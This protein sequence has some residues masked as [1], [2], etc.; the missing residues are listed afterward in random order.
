MFKFLAHDDP[1]W[2]SVARFNG[3]VSERQYQ[4]GEDDA[5]EKAQGRLDAQERE[6]KEEPRTGA[7][8]H[9]SSS[10]ECIY[11]LITLSR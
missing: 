10:I 4:Q 7:C 8:R 6:R 11:V 5:G 1:V 3:E 9:V 2:F